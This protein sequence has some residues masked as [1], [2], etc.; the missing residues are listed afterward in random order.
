MRTKSALV[1]FGLL[2]CAVSSFGQFNFVSID[3]PGALATWSTGINPRGQIVG[4]YLDQNGLQHGYVYSDGK[5]MTIDVPGTLA[6]LPEN[7][8]LETEV[9][10]INPEG[11]MV[12]DY[13]AP[14]SAPGAPACV[15]AY[16]PPCD[17]GFLYRHGVFENVLASG[18]LGSIPNGITPEGAIYGCVHDHDLG[19]SMFG[20]G[21]SPSGEFNILSFSPSM[22]NA[23][24]PGGDPVVGL[25]RPQ[26]ASRV[27]GFVIRDGAVNDYLFPGGLSTQLWGIN[28]EGSFVGV[29]RDVPG[30]AGVHG[31]MQPG[32]GSAPVALNFPGAISTEAFAINPSGTIVGLYSDQNGTHG[33]LAAPDHGKN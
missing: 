7:A 18:H 32:D 2:L 5:F 20:F 26:G 8:I 4:G 27:H 17:R 12:G 14:P 10:G 9:N 30:P 31:L 6:G 19:L 13:F 15:I 25:Y 24:T 16:S 23:A 11:E 29:Y 1:L 21:R 33:F 3:V 22:S 28:P